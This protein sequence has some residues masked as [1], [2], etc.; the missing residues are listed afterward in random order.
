MVRALEGKGNM[1]VLQMQLPHLAV[2]LLSKIPDGNER[3]R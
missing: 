2:D 1:A 3:V